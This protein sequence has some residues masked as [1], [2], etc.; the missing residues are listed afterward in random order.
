[1]RNAPEWL[2]LPVVNLVRDYFTYIVALPSFLDQ[3]GVI[4]FQIVLLSEQEEEE[5]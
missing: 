5:D 4:F 1:M 3:S 2:V